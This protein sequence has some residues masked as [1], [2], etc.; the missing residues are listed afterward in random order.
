MLASGD[1]A[2]R[3]PEHLVITLARVFG[4]E[5]SFLSA[6]TVHSCPCPSMVSLHTGSDLIF[7]AAWSGCDTEQ[8]TISFW[9]LMTSLCIG[10]HMFDGCCT[11]EGLHPSQ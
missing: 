3:I 11:V 2:L 8:Q 6:S 9:L 4:D 1:V 5:V 10:L 7:T